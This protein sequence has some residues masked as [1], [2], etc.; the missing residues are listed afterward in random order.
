MPVLTHIHTS[1]A[2]LFQQFCEN[3]EKMH[4]AGCVF[5]KNLIFV[6]VFYEKM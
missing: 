1:L 4:K 6:H 3:Q 5:F 2:L